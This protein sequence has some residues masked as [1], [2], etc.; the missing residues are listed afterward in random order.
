MCCLFGLMGY[1]SPLQLSTWRYAGAQRS[2]LDVTVDEVD[3]HTVTFTVTSTLPTTNTSDYKQVYTVFSTGDVR[4]TS[5][6][7]PGEDLPMIP[8]VGNMLTIPKEFDNVTWYGKGP[9]ENYIDR[10]T[11]YQVGVYQKNVD[12]FFVDYI[13]PQETGNRTD[14]RWVSLTNDD[15]VG[16]LAKAEGNTMEFNA[17]RYTPRAAEQHA[18]F[19]HAPRGP[20]HHPA[21]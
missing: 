16:L 18:P 15:G 19:L 5:T 10:Q 6:L 8:E 9:D 7:T 1:Y 4:V 13:K 3:D 2:L 14:V 11:G 21:P 17:L 12:D 20:G